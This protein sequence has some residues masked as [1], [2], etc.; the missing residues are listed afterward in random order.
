MI[1]LVEMK[2]SEKQGLE[3]AEKRS[4]GS[5]WAIKDPFISLFPNYIDKNSKRNTP[6]SANHIIASPT[7]APK[8][9][10]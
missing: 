1:T 7:E 5:A 3:F 6:H 2:N 8:S 4:N 9:T 10:A